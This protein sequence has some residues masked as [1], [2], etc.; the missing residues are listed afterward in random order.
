MYQPL[1]SFILPVRPKPLELASTVRSICAQTFGD[2]EVIALLDRDTGM[3]IELLRQLIPAQKL[4]TFSVNYQEMGFSKLLNFGVENAVG[5]FIARLDDDDV[6]APERI[7]K[8]IEIFLSKPKT[9]L[10]TSWANV[11]NEDGETIYEIRPSGSEH[12]LMEQLIRVNVIP[13]ST[14]L[15]KREKFL[16]VGGYR[17]QLVRCEDYDLWLRMVGTGNFG[18][19][20]QHLITY[21]SNPEGMTSQPIP[22]S[23]FRHL[24]NSR[25]HAVEQLG[26]P[27]SAFY[28][29]ESRWRFDQLL[30]RVQGRRQNRNRSSYL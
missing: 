13:H 15:F 19:V 5:N 16:E 6:C 23:S 10:V 17:T 24:A 22:F 11:V 7:E 21:L 28:L 18:S 29:S 1:V 8:Q 14:V 25:K 20:E 3:N 26:M 27:R 12:I 2:W 9:V 30:G 4:R